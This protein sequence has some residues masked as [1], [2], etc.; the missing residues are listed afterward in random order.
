[1]FIK[2][3]LLLINYFFIYFKYIPTEL[4]TKN[5]RRYFTESC[6]IITSHAIITDG[7]ITSV[8]PNDIQ[9]DLPTD[10]IRRCFTE[11]WQTITSHAIITYGLFVGNYNWNFRWIYSVGNIPAGIFFFG[12]RV[13]VCKTVGVP[14]VDVFF[15]CDRV[16][17]ENASYWRLVYWQIFSVGK[18]FTDRF[19]FYHRWN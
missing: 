18:Y 19:H 9:M 5:I 8:M 2:V 7:Y 15:I 16:S 17:D 14:S 10:N 1:L 12:A 6:Q 13:S 4:P 11:G 3:F